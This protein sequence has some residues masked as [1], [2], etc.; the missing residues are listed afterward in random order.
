[1]VEE[2][3]NEIPNHWAFVGAA[4]VANHYDYQSGCDAERL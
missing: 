1:M 4:S 2:Q 3:N